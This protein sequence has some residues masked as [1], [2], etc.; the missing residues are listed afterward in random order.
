MRLTRLFGK[1]IGKCFDLSHVSHH[2]QSNSKGRS[3]SCV[4]YRG[5]TI[6]FSVSGFFDNRII[7]HELKKAAL[8]EI[9]NERFLSTDK[10]LFTCMT[11]ILINKTVRCNDSPDVVNVC[12]KFI[13]LN[14]QRRSVGMMNT[15]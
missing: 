8:S 1:H 10:Q 11:L 4:C 13:F 5:A 6:F 12:T 9:D 7:S 2:L 3:L 14:R 15:G